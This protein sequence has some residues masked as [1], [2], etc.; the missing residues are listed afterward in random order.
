MDMVPQ[1]RVTKFEGDQGR[2]LHGDFRKYRIFMIFDDHKSMFRV[3]FA[4]VI[5]SIV[6]GNLFEEACAE[7]QPRTLRF[8]RFRPG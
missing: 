3:R 2:M 7:Y 8:G 6:P 5:V 1:I 4:F